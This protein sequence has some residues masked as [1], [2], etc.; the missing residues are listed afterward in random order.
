M[1]RFSTPAEAQRAARAAA[2]NDVRRHLEYGFDLNPFC[3]GSARIQWRRGY[4]NAGPRD[5]ELTLDYDTIYHRG[6]ASAFLMSNPSTCV[7]WSWRRWLVVRSVDLPS[8]Q[9]YED[10]GYCLDRCLSCE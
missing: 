8:E 2:V 7:Y 9:A 5:G 10:A 6:K 3:T 4:N 1:T